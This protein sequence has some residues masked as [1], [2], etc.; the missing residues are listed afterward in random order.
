MQR[1]KTFHESLGEKCLAYALKARRGAQQ[2]AH[3]LRAEGLH[4]RPV[5]HHAG[6]KILRHRIGDLSRLRHCVM[7][8]AGVVVNVAVHKRRV[9]TVDHITALCQTRM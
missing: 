5:D 6:K 7:G 8:V 1:R 2:P 4:H 3:T 9:G